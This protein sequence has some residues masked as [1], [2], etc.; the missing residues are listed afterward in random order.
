M[1]T[2]SSLRV[3]ALATDFERT[4]AELA[5]FVE[6]LSPEEWSTRGKNSPIWSLGADEERSVGV[7]AAHAASVIAIHA[8]MLSE[9]LAGRP[10]LGDGRWEVEGVAVW[11]ASVAAERAAVSPIDVLSELRAN[12][13][14][15]LE[16]LGSLDDSV[17]DR[18]AADVDR[19]AVGPF[20]PTLQTL[21]QFIDEA[22]TGHLRVHRESLRATVGR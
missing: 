22:L 9:A 11:N 2:V 1:T 8:G 15:A 13:V 4:A 3:Q 19:A 12:S 14:A 7:I 18:A 16:L 5:S 21:G 17:L 6:T 20:Y 10:M